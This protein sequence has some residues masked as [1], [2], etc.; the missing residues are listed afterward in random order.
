MQVLLKPWKWIPSPVEQVKCNRRQP[1]LEPSRSLVFE[2]WAQ[3]KEE[4]LTKNIGKIQKYRECLWRNQG[5]GGS[6][7][8]SQVK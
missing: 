7:V 4:E 1:K 6:S 5:R 2:R 8:K 3:G